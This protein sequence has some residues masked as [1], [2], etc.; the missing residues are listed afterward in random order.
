MVK[1]R[2]HIIKKFNNPDYRSRTLRSRKLSTPS[3]YDR[4]IDEKLVNAGFFHISQVRGQSDE[5]DNADLCACGEVGPCYTHVP[6][7]DR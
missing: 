3:D 6:S 4:R 1:L 2:K 5:P 7:A